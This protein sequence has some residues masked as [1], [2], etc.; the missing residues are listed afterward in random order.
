M[1]FPEMPGPWTRD[2]STAPVDEAATEKMREAI[3]HLYFDKPRSTGY[4]INTV[5]KDTPRRYMHV[6]KIMIPFSER[7]NGLPKDQMF[8]FPKNPMVTENRDRDLMCYDPKTGEIW[9]AI[10]YQEPLLTSPAMAKY[11]FGDRC[12]KAIKYNE[13]T[14]WRGMP[15]GYMSSQV[16]GFPKTMS[17]L[18]MA[19][20]FSRARSFGFAV[21]AKYVLAN[22]GPSSVTGL[23]SC[24]DGSVKDPSKPHI[25]MGA[26]LRWPPLT[27]SAGMGTETMLLNRLMHIRGAQLLM[28]TGDD[29]NFAKA[30]VAGREFNLSD[31]T[32]LDT[33]SLFSKA[34]VVK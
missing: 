16:S 8:P 27:S 24:T 32:G 25:L 31:F 23:A 29:V 2:V 26:K 13:A 6:G 15:F 17:M 33:M 4:H 18:H 14:E 12:T 11:G 30:I 19:L 34:V 7:A 20:L 28:T 10:T 22:L 5:T 3:G 1:D 21:S 9:E